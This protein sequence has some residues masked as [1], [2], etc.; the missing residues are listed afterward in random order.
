MDQKLRERRGAR[1][2]KKFI[3]TVSERLH[4]RRAL[5]ITI[6]F[7]SYIRDLTGLERL[8]RE[9]R[10]GT[11]LGELHE[12]LC[13]EFPALN[14]LSRSTLLAVGVEYQSRDFQLQDGHIVSLFPPVQ[15]G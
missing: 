12:S 11:R 2:G 3:S 15:G 7:F 10:E 9:V 14:E 13:A 1:S 5:N 6:Q 4:S 8:E